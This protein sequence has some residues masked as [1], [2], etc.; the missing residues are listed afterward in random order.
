MLKMPN[1]AEVP[2]VRVSVRFPKAEYAIV[3]QAAEKRKTAVNKFVVDAALAAA[4]G[5][6]QGECA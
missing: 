6:A 1:A 3:R 2:K 5:G 4:A